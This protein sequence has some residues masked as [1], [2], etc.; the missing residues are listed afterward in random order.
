MLITQITNIMMA[1][2]ELA[3]NEAQQAD[4]SHVERYFD[5]NPTNIFGLMLG[6]LV[7]LVTT[8]G[9]ILWFIGRQGMKWFEKYGLERKE[10]EEVKSKTMNSQLDISRETNQILADIKAGQSEMATKIEVMSNEI[11]GLKQSAD[12]TN[13]TVVDLEGKIEGAINDIEGIKKK[14]NAYLPDISETEDSAQ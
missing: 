6:G 9:T 1:A 3:A 8:M 4:P 11:H 7:I 5:A 13:Q 10:T 2:V 14:V 12:K